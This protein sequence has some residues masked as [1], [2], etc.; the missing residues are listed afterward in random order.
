MSISQ[1]FLETSP[2]PFVA[3]RLESLALCTCKLA[4]EPHL[5][6][7][8][9]VARLPGYN[10]AKAGMREPLD[11]ALNWVDRARPATKRRRGN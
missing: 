10:A 9:R 11:A 1:R 3:N 8:D 6:V 2:G 7:A 5:E 4:S